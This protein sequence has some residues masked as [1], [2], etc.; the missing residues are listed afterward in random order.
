MTPQFLPAKILSARDRRATEEQPPPNHRHKQARQLSP[1][2]LCGIA[3]SEPRSWNTGKAQRGLLSVPA[4]CGA[5]RSTDGGEKSDGSPHC[6]ETHV[7]AKT[8]S[9]YPTR[10]KPNVAVPRRWQARLVASVGERRPCRTPALEGWRKCCSG[11]L[12]KKKQRC[13][14]A[15]SC[16]Y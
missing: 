7:R 4:A 5:E 11:R 10:T 6:S 3:C 12:S 1:P 9:P 16:L 8:E 13:L 15:P 14:L 2:C